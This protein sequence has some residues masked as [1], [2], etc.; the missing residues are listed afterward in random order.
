MTD[1]P[2]I[3]TTTD[4]TLLREVL[5][6]EQLRRSAMEQTLL[7]QSRDRRTDELHAVLNSSWWK[8]AKLPRRCIFWA[9]YIVSHLKALGRKA[10]PTDIAPVDVIPPSPLYSFLNEA[11]TAVTN[12]EAIERMLLEQK[13][14]RIL[15]AAP[16]LAG[17][18]A[19]S[20][21]RLGRALRE[22]GHDVLLIAAA[23]GPVRAEAEAAGIPTAVSAGLMTR[24][25]WLD[26]ASP[27]NL[28]VLAG[29]GCAAAVRALNGMDVPV[30]WWLRE[31]GA[32]DPRCMVHAPETLTEDLHVA[33]ATEAARQRILSYRPKYAVQLLRED[34]ADFADEA[35]RAVCLAVTRHAFSPEALR[36]NGW[37]PEPCDPVRARVSVVIPA[38]NG[39]SDCERLLSGLDRQT[40]LESLEV[41]AVDSGSRDGT[42]A[43]CRRHGAR[44]I[45]IPNSM[46][47]HSFARNLAARSATGDIL[48]FMTQD[49][50]PT[51]DTWVHDL[52]A[53]ILSGEATA[54]SPAEEPPE[55]TDLYYV[56][57]S[58]NH[59]HYCG[60][61]K[62]DQLHRGL[63]SGSQDAQHR[64][65]ALNDVATA[66]RRDVFLRYLYRHDFGEDLDMGLR[67]LHGGYS[68]ALLKDVT[69]RHGH[70]RAA[71]YYVKRSLV[72]SVIMQE[73]IQHV[74]TEGTL[75]EK[76]VTA[77]LAE[78]YGA[79]QL[80]A[81]ELHGKP[82]GREAFTQNLEACLTRLS[83][84]SARALIEAPP[85]PAMADAII[86]QTIADVRAELVARPKKIP[87]CVEFIRDYMKFMF[88][89]YFDQC[90]VWDDQTTPDL[91][92][93]CINKHFATLIGAE[94]GCIPGDTP[95]TQRIKP[96]WRGV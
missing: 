26:I 62:A 12:R 74:A 15:L 94:L 17:E 34:G 47:S 39:E 65:G 91:V 60:T 54:V 56:L 71:G 83:K 31:E 92:L 22:L 32:L 9:R 87:L 66:I 13:A 58:L 76:V 73:R 77:L 90:A 41:V 7:M 4:E 35:A 96:L 6:S 85:C 1:H 51:S 84:M 5:A 44:V 37:R 19:Q 61:D 81:A 50:A 38:Y 27:F 45:E 89:P 72:G 86:D 18:S 8:L 14:W 82:C 29:V 69:V 24:K 68:I 42:V 48:L 30:L 20:L 78:A 36:H 16:D 28:T 3:P 93:D 33:A 2:T 59:R 80:M 46:F 11:G 64:F 67:L 79:V 55:G 21:L 40:G 88:W 49:A 53:P 23:E 57:S 70:N 52:I 25:G 10:A 43:C 75:P 95:L 63:G